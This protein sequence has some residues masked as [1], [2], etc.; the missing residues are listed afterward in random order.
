MSFLKTAISSVL[1]CFLFYTSKDDE[2]VG[3][4][5]IVWEANSRT[6]TF[7]IPGQAP[8]S[9]L[10]PQRFFENLQIFLQLQTYT[11]SLTST[12]TARMSNCPDARSK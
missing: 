1:L 12:A 11:T 5:Y 6:R 2:V 10:L 3:A 4:I 9:Q 8:P 7:A